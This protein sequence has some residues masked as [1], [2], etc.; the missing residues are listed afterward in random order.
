[1]IELDKMLFALVIL[2]VTVL[3]CVNIAQASDNNALLKKIMKQ[4][5]SK[6]IETNQRGKK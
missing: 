5:E 4:N 6:R 2:C 1:M 3:L